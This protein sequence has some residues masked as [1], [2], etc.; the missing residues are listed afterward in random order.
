V[1]SSDLEEAREW[2]RNEYAV[3]FRPNMKLDAQP[4]SIKPDLHGQMKAAWGEAP[5][6]TGASV[7]NN[8]I[9]PLL[10]AFE[11]ARTAIPDL[12]LILAPRWK[13]QGDGIAGIVEAA[14]YQAARRSAG[15]V[16]GRDE[17][18][19]I[20]DSYGELGT[21]FD[22]SFGVFMGHTLF[23]GMGHNPYEAI[24]QERRIIAGSIPSL[25]AT[26]YSYLRDIGLCAVAED[27]ASIAAAITAFEGDRAGG[28][29]AFANFAQARGFSRE[30]ARRLLDLADE[31]AV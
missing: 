23:G 22:L 25:L 31:S 15:Q 16:P 28:A 1:C 13:E 4:L 17:R 27:A 9:A 11:S 26:D 7:D 14:G 2:V 24:I 30:I 8:E 29:A 5:V 10:E 21:W 6:L 3:V 12:R 19:F 20:A 18:V